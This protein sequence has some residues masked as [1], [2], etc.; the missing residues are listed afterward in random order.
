MSI[1][2]LT[3]PACGAPVTPTLAG[4][5]TCTYCKHTLTSV[6]VASWDA[7]WRR[8]SEDDDSDDGSDPGHPRC[9]VLGRP[10]RLCGRLGSGSLSDVFLAESTRRPSE[11]VIIKVWRGDAALAPF[12][13]EWRLLSRLACN[14]RDAPFMSTLV[15][16]LVATGPLTRRGHLPRAAFVYRWTSGYQHTLRQIRVVYPDGVEPQTA[17][18]IWRRLLDLLGWLHANQVGHGAV[19]PEHVLVHPRDHG[20]LL[21]GWSSVCDL[22][23]TPQSQA[24]DLAGSAQA[25]IFVLGGTAD[26]PPARVPQ[27]LRRLLASVAAGNGPEREARA[28]SKSVLRAATRAFGPPTYHRFNLPGWR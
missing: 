4:L 25:V 26:R 22:E 18:W 6:P 10:Y 23:E 7:L 2:A 3:C 1:T 19:R 5:V 28:L 17:V 24:D 16:Q 20:A 27:E 8:A 11:R 12:A 15:P 21:A 13:R 14:G 9:R